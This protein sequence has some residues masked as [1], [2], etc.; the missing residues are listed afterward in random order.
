MSLELNM[1]D[2]KKLFL[3]FILLPETKGKTHQPAW[4]SIVL[5]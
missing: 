1:H 4:K 3:V 2:K 5:K